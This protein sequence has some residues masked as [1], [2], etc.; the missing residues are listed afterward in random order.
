MNRINFKINKDLLRAIKEGYYFDFLTQEIVRPSGLRKKPKIY[1]KQRYPSITTN[2][3]SFPVH[4]LVAY[5]LYGVAIFEKNTVIRH[6]DGNVL[7]LNKDNIKLGTHSQ[8]NLDKP[9]E[10]R[11]NA[12]K[13]AREF[14]LK[15]GIRKPQGS[16]L[17]EKDVLKIR[18]QLKD[19]KISKKQ[20][21]RQK[22]KEFNV[23]LSTIEAIIYN[24]N[25]KH[26]L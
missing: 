19:N 8:N 18:D 20:F 16:I 2:Y 14:Q 11:I 24:K 23:S 12:A 21:S 15:N 25:W 5:Q 13:K 10:K 22:A 1:G 3:G 4:K 7:N 26:L 9:K 17:S 6:L